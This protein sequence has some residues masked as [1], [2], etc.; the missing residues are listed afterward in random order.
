MLMLSAMLVLQL[1]QRQR[2][3]YHGALSRGAAH[4]EVAA[5]KFHPLAHPVE[6]EM[7]VRLQCTGVEAGAVVGHFDSHLACGAGHRNAL[8]APAAVAKTIGERFLQYPE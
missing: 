7:T 5:Q 4:F 2:R 3:P 6:P 1:R 8:I